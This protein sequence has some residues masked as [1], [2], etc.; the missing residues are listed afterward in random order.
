MYLPTHRSMQLISPTF[1]SDSPDIFT[2]HFLKHKLFILLVRA[3]EG[4]GGRWW[5]W[6]RWSFEK[7]V[8]CLL[9]V[10]ASGKEGELFLLVKYA[11]A[12]ESGGDAR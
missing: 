12:K 4:R 10:F 9:A 5:W 8:L 7:G 6:W 3:R 2:T 1:R 11:F